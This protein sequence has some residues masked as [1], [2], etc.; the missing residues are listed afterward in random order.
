MLVL[1]AAASFSAALARVAQR[2]DGCPIPADTQ[3]QAG[4]ALS[5]RWSVGVPVHFRGLGPDGL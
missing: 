3:S 5:T 1:V 4:G 2:G